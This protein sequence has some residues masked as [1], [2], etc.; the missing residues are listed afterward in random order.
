MIRLANSLSAWGT[1]GFQAALKQ[2][3]EQLDPVQLPLQQGL[4]LSSHVAASP[5]SAII[6]RVDEDPQFIH[7]KAGIA[8]SGIIAGCS[9]T[10]DPTPMSEQSEY[11]E[12]LL[13]IDKRSAETTVT[14][15]RE[16]AA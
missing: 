2:E 3:I 13:D 10:D 16:E 11:C 1:P 4:A 7:A 8:Y 5:F 9:C 14:L 12:V 15:L 6:L